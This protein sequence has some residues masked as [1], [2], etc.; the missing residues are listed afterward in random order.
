VTREILVQPDLLARMELMVLTEPMVPRDQKEIKVIRV[1][2]DQQARMELMVL[3][4][5]KVQKE[6]KAIP[7]IRDFRDHKD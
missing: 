1:Q 7:E 3:T 6:T 4:E 5:H 2:P